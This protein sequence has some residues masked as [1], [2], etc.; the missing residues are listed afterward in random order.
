[1]H[2]GWLFST[3]GSC[4]EPPEVSRI[5][6][7]HSPDAPPASGCAVTSLTPGRGSGGF[8]NCCRVG[9]RLLATPGKHGWYPCPP[10]QHPSPPSPKPRGAHGHAVP[11]PMPGR[12]SGGFGK[13]CGARRRLLATPGKQRWCPCPPHFTAVSDIPRGTLRPS[14]SRHH[15][16]CF[17][18][19]VLFDYATFI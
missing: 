9:G 15:S 6:G 13:C 3:S 11:S 17:C 10:P 2:R 14:R 1:M 4:R 5:H 12:G 7:S 18:D 8:R 16:S 19:R